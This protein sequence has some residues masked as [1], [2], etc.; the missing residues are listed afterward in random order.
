MAQMQRT[1][2][3]WG[4]PENCWIF[5]AHGRKL[6]G[7]EHEE[8]PKIPTRI[9]TATDVT[10]GA[11]ALRVIDPS[12]GHAIDDAGKIPLR[13]RPP[14]F[15]GL[16]EI[17]VGQ[18][19]SK[20]SAAA[21][22]SRLIVEV[23]PL[24]AEQ[25]LHL[26]DAPLIRAGLSRAKQKTLTAIA[27][28]IVG[29]NLDLDALCEI[30]PDEALSKLTAIHGIGPWT[31]EVFLLFCAGHADIFPAGDIALQQALVDIGLVD[32]RPGD[33]QTRKI[34]QKWSPVRGIAARLLWSI[35]A[36]HRARSQMPV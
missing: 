4:K 24:N 36:K 32:E 8:N 10:A 22:Y 23:D 26:G 9:R 15:A 5:C 19:V 31:A 13:L 3:A 34:A 17:V 11:E 29:D 35:Y 21:M 28:A 25:I 16:A 30:A 20:A 33:I 7:M 2:W 1:I 12:L 14:G 6:G 27:T 18:Q